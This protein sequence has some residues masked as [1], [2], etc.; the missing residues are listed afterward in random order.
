MI[1][2]PKFDYYA[3]RTIAEAADR[4]AAHPDAMLLAGGTDLLP[5]MK[6]RQQ[7]PSVVVGLA[8]IGE[9]RL[10]RNGSGHTFGAGLTLSEIVRDAGAARECGALHQAAA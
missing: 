4:L 5:N 8:G 3:P 6:R 10:R 2:L 9:L 1:R 7:T